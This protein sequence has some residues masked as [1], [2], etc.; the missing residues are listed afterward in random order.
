M[1]FSRLAA[2][3]FTRDARHRRVQL[4]FIQCV[5]VSFEKA[6][7]L[8]AHAEDLIAISRLQNAHERLEV[9]T[10]RDDGQLVYRAA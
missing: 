3:R 2:W 6:D 9:K 1:K 4:H 5:P 10:V 8:P 7:L